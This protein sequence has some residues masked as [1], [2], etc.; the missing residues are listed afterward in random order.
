MD[1]ASSTRAQPSARRRSAVA[2]N[3]VSASVSVWI[4]G[5]TLPAKRSRP[6][7]TRTES[8]G[9]AAGAQLAA[10]GAGVDSFADEHRLGA[11]WT[12]RPGV[13]E[14]QAGDVPGALE[15]GAPVLTGD[16]HEALHPH[17]RRPQARAQAQQ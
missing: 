6:G 10:E 17:Q 7:A 1:S 8:P 5:S 11:A 3:T 2:R 9:G 14:A 4:S 13:A 16:V 15:E 12:R